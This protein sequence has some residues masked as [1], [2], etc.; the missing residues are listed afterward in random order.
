MKTLIGSEK[1]VIKE[2]INYYHSQS[3]E[4]AAKW[5]SCIIDR[6]LITA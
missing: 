4:D 2:V 1:K 3:K 5:R 6:L